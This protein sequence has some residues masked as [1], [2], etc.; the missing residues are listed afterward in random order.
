MRTFTHTCSHTHTHSR[1]YER[2]SRVHERR[3]CA[4]VRIK[5]ARSS[6]A[7][8]CVRRN[9]MPETKIC[10]DAT[11]IA[12][13]L[14]QGAWASSRKCGRMELG[15]WHGM[16]KMMEAGRSNECLIPIRSEWGDPTYFLR[17]KSSRS[18]L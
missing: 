11:G 17:R 1:T 2:G 15:V 8:M 4:C 18:R 14:S 9:A 12:A 10:A 5:N 6:P 13:N 3:M 7:R 16:S